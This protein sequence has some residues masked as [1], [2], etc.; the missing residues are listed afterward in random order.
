MRLAPLSPR[1][2]EILELLPKRD[3]SLIFG[4]IPDPR[5]AFRTAA[6][7]AGPER[8]W[9]HLFG[10]FSPHASPSGAPAGTSFAT[11]GAGAAP[12]WPIATLMRRLRELIS[13]N[14]PATLPRPEKAAGGSE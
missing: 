8:V 1:A 9:L 11:P 6:K 10:T 3:D 5:R 14:G 12:G 13:G 2:L 4:R 7:A